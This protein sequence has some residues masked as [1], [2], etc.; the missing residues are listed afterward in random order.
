V[1]PPRLLPAVPLQGATVSTVLQ[2]P[3]VISQSDMEF[4]VFFYA[5]SFPPEVGLAPMQG[6]PPAP[7]HPFLSLTTSVTLP[8][9]DCTVLLHCRTKPIVESCKNVRFGCLAGRGAE[10][11]GF[12][13]QLVGAGMSPL[14]NFWS[15]VYDFTPGA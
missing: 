1:H 10:Y 4:R 12:G 3:L 5:F 2:H 14:H 7:T 11:A 9:R 8:N 13:A 15:H 6:K